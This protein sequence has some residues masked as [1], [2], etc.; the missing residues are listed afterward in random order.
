MNTRFRPPPL[1]PRLDVREGPGGNGVEPAPGRFN[2][3][4][5]IPSVN[6]SDP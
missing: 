2:T 6:S 5:S 4:A 1:D 3:P